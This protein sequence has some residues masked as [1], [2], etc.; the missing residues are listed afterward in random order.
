MGGGAQ[1]RILARKGLRHLSIPSGVTSRISSLTVK[2]RRKSG[3]RTIPSYPASPGFTLQVPKNSGD[4]EHDRRLCKGKTPCAQMW[5]TL[6]AAV[7]AQT[8]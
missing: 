5:P 1:T 3:P 7:T 8:M 4:E 6:M 2:K